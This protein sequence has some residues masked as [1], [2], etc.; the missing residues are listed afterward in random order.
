[1]SSYTREGKT[2]S[3]VTTLLKKI[4]PFNQES[5]NK[6]CAKEGYDP[7]IIK[8]LSTSIGNKVSSWIANR[9]REVLFLDPPPIGETEHALYKGIQ[10]FTEAYQVLESEVTVYCDEFMYAGT[11]DGLVMYK[12]K[13]YLMDWKTYGA[14]RGE[15]KRDSK[16]IK[17]VSYQLSMYRYALGQ[18]YPLAVVVFKGDGTY[19][20][21]ELT[22]TEDWISK[23]FKEEHA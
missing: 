18:Q 1:M 11:F 16:K 22:Y 23:L 10:D 9:V 21:E 5:F 3:S 6:W 20:I 17:E 14:W 4:F 2:Y 13:K 7:E 15:Y 19:D 8:V 12:D